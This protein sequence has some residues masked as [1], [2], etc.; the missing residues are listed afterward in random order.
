M[1]L[2]RAII[3]IPRLTDLGYSRQHRTLLCR[4]QSH[5]G[6]LVSSLAGRLTTLRMQTSLLDIR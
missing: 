6:L 4:V 2:Q 5:A 3:R 1:S